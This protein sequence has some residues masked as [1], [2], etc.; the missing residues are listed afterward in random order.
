MSNEFTLRP[1][2]LTT[3][4]TARRGTGPVSGDDDNANQDPNVFNNTTAA[5]SVCVRAA[6]AG[7]GRSDEGPCFGSW[8]WD[9]TRC[10]DALPFKVEGRVATGI[11]TQ[12]SSRAMALGIYPG[13]RYVLSFATGCTYT[14]DVWGVTDLGAPPTRRESGSYNWTR[15]S[16]TSSTDG[17]GGNN[18]HAT[19]ECDGGGHAGDTG[20]AVG[21][22]YPRRDAPAFTSSVWIARSRFE[23]SFQCAL[24]FATFRLV[25]HP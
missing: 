18:A 13:S 25:D 21:L 1:A 11:F 17:T 5:S 7:H 9:E 24:G 14:F 10:T 22:A 3:T 20:G 12:V 2:N 16:R 6:R 19:L 4:R 23:G 15:A 8:S